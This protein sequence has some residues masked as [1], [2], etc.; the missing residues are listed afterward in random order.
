M[1]D[2]CL[3]E[4][5]KDIVGVILSNILN[6]FIVTSMIFFSE[7]FL[8]WRVIKGLIIE[9][10]SKPWE[11]LCK[12]IFIFYISKWVSWCCI[13]KGHGEHLLLHCPLARELWDMIFFPIWGSVVMP[14]GVI[15]YRFT[16][17]LASEWWDLESHPSLFDVVSFFGGKEMLE[18]CWGV[19][20][21]F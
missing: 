21:L 10:H 16:C 4:R 1:W 3:I 5:E 9:K 17:L 2:D 19:N 18:F 7:F 6:Q 13:C 20:R 14:W 11:I 15:H 12:K 8:I